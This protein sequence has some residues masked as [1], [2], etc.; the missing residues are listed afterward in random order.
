[1]GRV[2]AMKGLDDRTQTDFRVSLALIKIFVTIILTAVIIPVPYYW[3]CSLF[4]GRLE[5]Y[6][7][8]ERIPFVKWR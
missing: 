6:E 3:R 4:S 8:T 1:M 7:H 5:V 2:D